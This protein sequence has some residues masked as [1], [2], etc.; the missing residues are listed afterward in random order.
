MNMGVMIMLASWDVQ[1]L[2]VFRSSGGFRR[3]Y[4]PCFVTDAFDPFSESVS[5]RC[6][7]IMKGFIGQV[8]ASRSSRLRRR[9]GSASTLSMTQGDEP[10]YEAVGERQG[11]LLSRDFLQGST[12]S[13]HRPDKSV[14]EED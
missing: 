5:Q 2:G 12:A 13:N 3:A 4:S 10:S 11:L 7:S 8:F 14:M 9:G 1:N 6:C